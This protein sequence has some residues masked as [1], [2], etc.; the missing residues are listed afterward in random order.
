[1]F[2]I[3]SVV[4][5]LTSSDRSNIVRS[6]LEKRKWNSSCVDAFAKKICWSTSLLY[7]DMINL[8]FSTKYPLNITIFTVS[9]LGTEQSSWI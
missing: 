7:Y 6:D 5:V 4:D 1:M 2:S 3:N 9:V 8:S